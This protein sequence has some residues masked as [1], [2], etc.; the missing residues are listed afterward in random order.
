MPSARVKAC[1]DTNLLLLN[2]DHAL[3]RGALDFLHP[4]D[5]ATREGV[6]GLPLDR[7]F[8][9]ENGGL[10][11]V[12]GFAD[13]RVELDVAQEWNAELS[14]GFFDAAAGEYIDFVLA[15]WADEVAHVF[16]H[17]DEVDFH[18]L[19]HLDGFPAIL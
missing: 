13:G 2:L 3:R 15:V 19:E 11:C 18:L 17:A 9:P 5:Y 14:G 7:L 16:D 4:A 8:S 1:P 12:A 6:E 10:A